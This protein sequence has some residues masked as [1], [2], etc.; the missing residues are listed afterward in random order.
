MVEWELGSVVRPEGYVN[1]LRMAQLLSS[2][3][4]RK[5]LVKN[6]GGRYV[7]FTAQRF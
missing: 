4:K 3:T 1:Q 7:P 5:D 6:L 2:A